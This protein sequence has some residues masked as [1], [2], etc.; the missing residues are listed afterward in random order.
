MQCNFFEE[1]ENGWF[2][3][4]RG[5]YGF[6]LNCLFFQILTDYITHQNGVKNPILCTIWR[7]SS[8]IISKQGRSFWHKN[9]V[10]NRT[11]SQ[12]M[13]DFCNNGLSWNVSICANTHQVYSLGHV[14]ILRQFSRGFL[15]LH[16]IS[17]FTKRK[18]ILIL[19]FELQN[20]G[21]LGTLCNFL[22]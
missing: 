13:E 22:I 18:L 15:D 6:I 9:V 7:T 14:S 16:S 20:I 4:L 3:S 17:K 11:F 10:S 8:K 1:L 21:N 19:M 12:I 5:Q 2:L